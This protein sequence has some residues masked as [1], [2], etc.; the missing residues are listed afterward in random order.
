V[1]CSHNRLVLKE[2]PDLTYTL[3]LIESIIRDFNEEFYKL[4][5]DMMLREIFNQVRENVSF[6]FMNE[7]VENFMDK[8]KSSIESMSLS[9]SN[10]F[11]QYAKEAAK[12]FLSEKSYI[13]KYRD[14]FISSPEYKV[15]MFQYTIYS[16]IPDFTIVDEIR[17]ETEEVDI[18]NISPLTYKSNSHNEKYTSEKYVSEL[19]GKLLGLNRSISKKDFKKICYKTFR[20]NSDKPKVISLTPELKL[21]M[22][23]VIAGCEME[24]KDLQKDMNIIIKYIMSNANFIYNQAKVIQ[25]KEDL[26]QLEYSNYTSYIYAKVSALRSL[27][28]EFEKALAYKMDAIKQRRKE[29]LTIIHKVIEGKTTALK[30]DVDMLS[31]CYNETYA[32]DNDDE[33]NE[34]LFTVGLDSLFTEVFSITHNKDTSVLQ[35]SIIENLTDIME[36]IIEKIKEFFENFKNK[37]PAGEGKYDESEKKIRELIKK[38]DT[39]ELDRTQHTFTYDVNFMIK[40]ANS[41]KSVSTIQD[42]ESEMADIGAFRKKYFPEIAAKA[43]DASV[44]A[45]WSDACKRAFRGPKL[46]SAEKIVDQALEYMN[47]ERAESN[48]EKLAQCGNFLIK[49]AEYIKS[50]I[51]KTKQQQQR[52]NT[53]GNKNESFSYFLLEDMTSDEEKK[54]MDQARKDAKSD[55]SSDKSFMGKN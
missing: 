6:N 1:V 29:Y 34:E 37:K 12:K 49:D 10:T 36:T 23:Q 25:Q 19:R 2:N 46:T 50:E 55:I 54:E 41:F 38:I 16:N 39:S 4:S 27:L 24:L 7:S 40:I 53:S 17:K 47:Q 11:N 3:P 43:K 30:E 35:E 14:Q 31:N 32:I 9:L 42:I 20:N 52:N 44:D 26:S 5:E 13:D 21:H 45:N 15:R 28:I 51:Q 33:L 8:F 22:L 48:R 18:K